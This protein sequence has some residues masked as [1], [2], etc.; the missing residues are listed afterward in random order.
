MQQGLQRTYSTN[1]RK[2]FCCTIW[3]GSLGQSVSFKNRHSWPLVYSWG[4]LQRP[5]AGEKTW[6]KQRSTKNFKNHL[7]AS[8]IWPFLDQIL[9]VRNKHGFYSMS[10]NYS[11][12]LKH[13]HV[14]E[15]SPIKQLIIIW[16]KEYKIF[17]K[18]C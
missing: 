14:H 18:Y 11:G 2:C 10:L 5:A 12:V 4:D 7:L 8:M 3:Y 9:V 13:A 17:D 16:K 1:C 15:T 6:T